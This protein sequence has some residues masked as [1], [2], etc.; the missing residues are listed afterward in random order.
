AEL[1]AEE[2]TIER[3][4]GAVSL[5]HAPRI[6]AA[7]R[8]REVEAAQLYAAS[9]AEA[10]GRGGGTEV[11]LD[12]YALSVL[13]N[14]L[15]NYP[16][17]RDAALRACQSDAPLP[18]TSLALPELVDAAARDGK[19]ELAATA[20]EQL[21]ARARA[22]GTQWAQGLAARSQALLSSGPAAD[23]RYREAIERLGGCRMAVYL[24]RT[25]LVYGEWLRREGR[26]QDAR[27]QLRTAHELLSDMGAKAFA[28]RAA[29]ELRATGE[30]P[31]T[32]TA[33]RPRPS[34]LKSCTSRGSW[35]P[36][37]PPER[38]VRSCSSARAPSMPTCATSSRSWASPPA[39]SCE[40][41]RST[42]LRATGFAR[43]A[44][45]A[46]EPVDPT[47]PGGLAHPGCVRRHPQC[48]P[49]APGATEPEAPS[50]NPS[51]SSL[52]GAPTA[53]AWRG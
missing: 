12:K 49:Q 22:S 27:E 36:E 10:A 5:R 41:C 8:G 29:R 33:R 13:H 53:A 4:T 28:A 21:S 38:S 40:I 17:A 15:G 45:P 19:P 39:A 9:V 32:R 16:A 42:E 30:H 1:A 14:G 37:P 34:P 47:D 2:A 43:G 50:N 26:R 35:P 25:H 51:R 18:H 3:V 24:A 52:S 44:R 23:E 31:R 46:G 6:L 11:T 48:A 20:L 7:W